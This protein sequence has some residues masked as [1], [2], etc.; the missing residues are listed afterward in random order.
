MRYQSVKVLKEYSID[1]RF[2]HDSQLM[3]RSI[4]V[5][6]EFGNHCS[7]NTCY[8]ACNVLPD[9]SLTWTTPGVPGYN[10]ARERFLHGHV[11][12]PASISH[13]PGVSVMKELR[14]GE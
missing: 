8:V 6:L 4:G 2:I 14:A 11:P 3:I 7:T 5:R 10:V 1:Y 13:L 9:C 12:A